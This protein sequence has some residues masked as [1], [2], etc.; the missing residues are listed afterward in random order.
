[1]VDFDYIV[2][3]TG[4]GG[5]PVAANLAEAGFRVLVL[6]AGGSDEN[7][8]YQVPA[9]HPNASEDEA[10]SWEFFV[11]HYEDLAQQKKDWK[12]TE[13][14]DGVFYPRAATIGGCTAHNA[15]ILVYPSNG[16]WDRIAEATGDRSWRGSRMRKYFQRLED[17]RYRPV[18]RWLHKLLRFDLTRHG[19][20]GWLP[21]EEADPK[22]VLQD[23][24]L[25]N[26]FKRSALWNLFSARNWFVALF[27]IAFFLVT[28][29]DPN[30]WWAVRKRREG[31]RQ[32]PLT[33]DRGAR[34]GSRERL[35]AVREAHPENLKIRTG[36][37]V[38]RVLF[39]DDPD[40]TPR[41]VG[42]EYLEGRHLYQ[43]DPRAPRDGAQAGDGGAGGTVRQVRARREVILAGGAFNTPQLLQLSGVGPRELLERH[44]I[45]VRVSS[46]G[47][48][49]NL[50]DRYEISIV[51]EMKE[52]FAALADATMRP[53]EPGVK[54]DPAL[55]QWKEHR[56]GFY[57]T[58]GGVLSILKRSDPACKDADLFVFALPTDFRGYYPEYS[59]R[60]QEAKNKLTWAVLKG[61]THNPA[62][63]VE[64]VSA[65]P[66]ERPQ[67][68]FRCFDPDCDPEGKDMA[69]MVEGVRFIQSIACGSNKY[70]HRTAWPEKPLE[71]DQQIEDYVRDEAWGHHASCTCKIGPDDDPE[72]VLDSRFNVRGTRGLRVVDASV[73]PHIPGLFIVS[74][75]YMVAEKASA[76]ILE[77]AKAADRNRAGGET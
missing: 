47:V 29:G 65:D 34:A 75:I 33:R 72:A 16:D 56:S 48:G 67:I 42:V 35:L 38:S 61:Y 58:N 37:L 27:R 23:N 77:D 10:T 76:V 28:L 13:S 9:F 2:V 24:E 74:A 57:T 32:M 44:E 43:A 21:V 51:Y 68:D 73:F 64:I 62:G 59:T 1:M 71:T 12:F 55:A 46:P 17:C 60:T 69:A 6:E 54:T 14:E 7:L 50:Q 41:A 36:A 4:A 45:P 52:P 5:G 18:W 66:R 53:P 15:M 49:K 3:G 25:Y 8:N 31:L 26:V 63:T 40:G 70:I 11:R 22:L 39:E 30:T 20:R 19:F